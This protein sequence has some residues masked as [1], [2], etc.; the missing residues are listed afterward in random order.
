MA[1]DISWDDG[2]DVT[3]DQGQDV[4]WEQGQ[5][6]AAKPI[7]GLG[8]EKTFMDRAEEAAAQ[9]QP[10]APLATRIMEAT[11]EKMLKAGAV[12]IEEAIPAPTTALAAGLLSAK[13]SL[14]QGRPQTSEDIRA[15]YEELSAEKEG[16]KAEAPGIADV[17]S[18][19]LGAALPIPTGA[20]KGVV[21]GAGLGADVAGAA[22]QKL[23]GMAEKAAVGS[24][25]AT[26]KQLAKINKYNPE[27]GRFLL[28]EKI[29]TAGKN[30]EDLQ[31]P[32][33]AKL[34]ESENRLNEVYSNLDEMTGGNTV[35][36]DSIIS[37]MEASKASLS[38]AH[39]NDAVREAIDSEIQNL[40]TRYPEGHLTA[41]EAQEIKSA[42]GSTGYGQTTLPGTRVAAIDRKIS[43]I[44]KDS[45]DDAA[46]THAPEIAEALTQENK[47]ASNLKAAYGIVSGKTVPSMSPL[48]YMAAMGGAIANPV[49]AAAPMAARQV[50]T[51]GATTT[52]SLANKAS[53]VA[54]AVEDAMARLAAN[55]DTAAVLDAAVRAV[56]PATVRQVVS[57]YGE[58]DPRTKSLLTRLASKGE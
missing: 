1:A 33:R 32:I 6:L 55:P 57:A 7:E 52:A 53:G 30:V 2:E 16:I 50:A 22:A 11:P 38:R 51:R 49:L 5:D 21:K 39:T 41:R 47:R 15:K 3:W 56:G 46:K 29:A 44:Y 17:T 26:A 43:R 8:K 12:G 18:G 27:L 35:P 45:L 42:Y 28:D 20:G 37:R 23:G 34:T 58:D 19:A 4:T 9:P 36:V 24:T 13:E 25:K 10:E 14:A 31:A 40:K 54:G 48:E